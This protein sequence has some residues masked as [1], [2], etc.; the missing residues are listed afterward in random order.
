MMMLMRNIFL[1]ILLLAVT[2][3]SVAQNTQIPERQRN[4]ILKLI[5]QYSLA[6]DN[7]DTT[8]LKTIL[9]PR[10]D[11]LVS[12]GEWRI[13]TEA[14]V[15][16]MLRSSSGNPGRRILVV[17]RIRMLARNCAIVDCRYEIASENGESRKMWSSFTV[18]KDRGTWK[19]A[20][21]RNMLPA[22]N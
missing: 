12:T 19:I 3:C 18:V 15:E 16:G 17:D 10:I 20:A 21:I 6:R 9:A 8:L 2:L 7:R 4:Q 13:G 22:G 5:D 11:Q 14:A 1:P